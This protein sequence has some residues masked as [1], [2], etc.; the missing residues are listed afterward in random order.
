M[1]EKLVADVCCDGVTACGCWAVGC[2]E[3]GFWVALLEDGAVC[4]L[5]ALSASSRCLI[6]SVWRAFCSSVTGSFLV[7]VE[8]A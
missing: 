4:L 2:E 3:L 8:I 6:N 7:G 1:V 5:C